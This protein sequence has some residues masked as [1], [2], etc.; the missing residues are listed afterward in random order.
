MEVEGFGT[1]R[2]AVWVGIRW[3]LPHTHPR[4]GRTPGL[5]H[6]GVLSCG[7]LSGADAR[8]LIEVYQIVEHLVQPRLTG[9]ASPC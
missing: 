1:P 7:L 9:K 6:P 3:T 2:T 8:C 4:Q 5:F